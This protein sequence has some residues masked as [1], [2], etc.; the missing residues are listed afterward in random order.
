MIESDGPG[1]AEIVVLQLSQELRRKGHHV[2]Y[3][4]PSNGSGWLRN[5]F[6]E[7]GFD[8]DTFVLRRPVDLQCVRGMENMLRKHRIDVVHSHEFTMAV[9]GSAAA[10]RAGIPHVTT[11]HGNQK[12]MLRLRRRVALR[13]AFRRTSLPVACSDATRLDVERGLGLPS[14]SLHTV[15]NG[16]PHVPGDRAPVRREL[17]LTI[18]EVLIFCVGNVVARKGHIQLLRALALLEDEGQVY[19]W[20]VAIAGDRRDAAPAI[21]EFV[22]DRGWSDRVKL[23]GVR[24]DI[25]NLL[26]AADIFAM[27]SL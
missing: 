26:A 10:S 11:M 19:P 6:L 9:Y 23:L 2:L 1:G 27:P 13:W 24:S 7:E 21:D 5:R 15:H 12:M 17:G 8:T 20:R 16:V 3:V 22:A 25:N 18:E 14:G 4:G